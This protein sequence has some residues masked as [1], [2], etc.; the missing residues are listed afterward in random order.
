VYDPESNEA[1]V[2]GENSSVSVR[3]AMGRPEVGVAV[4]AG[5]VAASTNEEVAVPVTEPVP[6]GCT[7]FPDLLGSTVS[8][9]DGVMEAEGV[10]EG[11]TLAAGGR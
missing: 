9:E 6:L 1:G 10:W 8:D 7:G 11:V 5:D 3:L 4:T 2:A